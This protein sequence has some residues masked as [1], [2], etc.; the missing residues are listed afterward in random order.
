MQEGGLRG[1]SINM[2]V[3]RTPADFERYIHY[4]KE[5]E[6]RVYELLRSRF[7][8][9]RPPLTA[10]QALAR[11]SRHRADPDPDLS[12][13][14]FPIE[15]KRRKF[16]F[17]DAS[18]YP[19]ESFYIDEEYK[20][21]DKSVP[22]EDYFAMSMIERRQ[23]IKPF[24]MYLTSNR[25]MTHMGLVIP[26]SKNYWTLDRKTLWAD[27][28]KGDSWACQLNKVLFVPVAEWRTILTWV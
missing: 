4:G 5:W 28:R 17:T 10:E 19:Y 26:A 14:G 6:W 9:I 3:A 21:R 18:D 15:C 20:L 22:A 1:V 25:A 13:S 27:E 7:P 24:M 11:F 23:H 2:V 8:N 16:D 12:I